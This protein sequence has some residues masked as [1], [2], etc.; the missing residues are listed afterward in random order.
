MK[1]Y[2]LYIKNYYFIYCIIS[3]KIIPVKNILLNKNIK[4]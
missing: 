4:A 3:L 2:H 1:E